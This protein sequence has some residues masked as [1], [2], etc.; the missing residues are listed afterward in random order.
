MTDRD[1]PPLRK[2]T[3]LSGKL[4]VDDILGKNQTSCMKV[5]GAGRI[6]F[7]VTDRDDLFLNS[8]QRFIICR[9]KHISAKCS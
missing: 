7:T 6:E 1:D 2:S 4:L 9:Y 8:K 3:R 5:G